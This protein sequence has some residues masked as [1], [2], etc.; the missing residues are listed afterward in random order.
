MKAEEVTWLGIG[1]FAF[2]LGVA[3]IRYLW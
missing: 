1:F 3:V 2:T